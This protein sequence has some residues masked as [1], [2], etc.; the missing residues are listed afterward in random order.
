MEG[1][2]EQVRQQVVAALAASLPQAGTVE[3]PQSPTTT[4]ATSS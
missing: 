4:E 1:D 3:A 2:G